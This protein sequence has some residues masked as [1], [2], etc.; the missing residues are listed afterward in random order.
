VA[1]SQV[2]IVLGGIVACLKWQFSG[3]SRP[4]WQLSWMT[5][6]QGGSFYNLLVFRIEVVL[7]GDCP[8]WQLSG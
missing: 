2:A 3:C 7:G 6:F 1:V 5:V 4:G 8:R